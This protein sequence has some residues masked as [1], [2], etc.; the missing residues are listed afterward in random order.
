MKNFN[1]SSYTQLL[2]H[3]E[4]EYD[5]LM[6][7]GKYYCIDKEML[8]DTIHD[9]FLHFAEKEINL[10]LIKFPHAY[11]MK[12]FKRRLIDCHRISTKR[13]LNATLICQDIA[14]D[15][16][17][18]MMEEKESALLVTNNL[19]LIYEKLPGRL[20]KVIFL[21][22]YEGLTNDQIMTQTGL[23]LRSVYNNLSEGIKMMR[24]EMR[25]LPLPIEMTAI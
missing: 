6:Q 14:L 9:L 21:K 12:S 10:N 11:I 13:A 17:N 15:S 22:F 4:R 1:Q 23:S 3:Y 8:E 7:F 24:F 19:N 25:K 2:V 5:Q 18:I 20:K 16:I